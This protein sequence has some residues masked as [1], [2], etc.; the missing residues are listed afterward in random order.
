MLGAPE[1][2]IYFHTVRKSVYT[3]VGMVEAAGRHFEVG[4]IRLM[5]GGED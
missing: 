2:S 4:R 5:I 1:F 3:L